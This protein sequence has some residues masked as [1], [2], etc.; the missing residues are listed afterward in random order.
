MNGVTYVQARRKTTRQRSLGLVGRMGQKRFGP[1][2]NKKREKRE[3][4]EG[5]GGLLLVGRSARIG[6]VRNTRT[7]GNTSILIMATRY[8]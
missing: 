7:G 6:L 8:S 1:K 4:T 2:K 5:D 3:K